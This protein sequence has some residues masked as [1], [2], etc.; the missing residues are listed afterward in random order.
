MT[1]QKPG[2]VRGII[3]RADTDEAP[4]SATV[5]VQSLVDAVKTAQ[6]DLEASYARAHEDLATLNRAKQTLCDFLKAADLDI[7]C[8]PEPMAMRTLVQIDEAGT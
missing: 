8:E 7:H 1:K 6:R 5:T 2:W 4:T 3:S